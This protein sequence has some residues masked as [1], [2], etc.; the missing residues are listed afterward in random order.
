MTARGFTIVEFLVTV[1]LLAVGVAAMLL[2]MQYSA[3]QASYLRQY[4]VMV[5]EAQGQLEL[6][7]ATPYASLLVDPACCTAGRTRTVAVSNEQLPGNG[8]LAVQIIGI[9]GAP[10]NLLDVR[11]AGCWMHRGRYIGEESAAGLRNCRDRAGE[12]PENTW[13]NSSV[14]LSTRVARTE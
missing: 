3:I 13:V 1:V 10:Y 6:L 4:Y 9:G 7:L 14:M 12:V 11:V 2:G 5:N 8:M